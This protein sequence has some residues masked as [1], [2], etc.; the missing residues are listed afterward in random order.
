MKSLRNW[1]RPAVL[2]MKG[3]EPGE[4]PK[5]PTTIKLNTNENPY[6]PSAPV[7]GA[8]KNLE[9]LR[10]RRYPEPMADTLRHALSRLYHW[11]AEGILIGN[12]SDE[13]LSLVF[14]AS[15]GKGDVVQ[16]PDVT[17]SLY[18]S[19]AEFRE[20]KFKEVKLD[21]EFGVDFKKFSN[22]PRLTLW[23]Y[24]NPPIG[25]CFGMAEM[26]AFCRKAKGLVLI[27]EA[28][29]DFAEDNCISIA[30]S[31]SNV[32]V[33]RTMS[34][35]FSM[36]GIRLGYLFG[37]PQVV[38]QLM[39]VK[40]S[41]NISYMSQVAAIAA[42]SPL[43]LRNMKNNVKKIRLERNTLI[44]ALR[45]MGFSVPDS[46]ANF[47]LAMRS[48]KPSTESLYKNLKKNRILVRYFSH[49]RLKHSL[50]ISVG[51]PAENNRLLAELKKLL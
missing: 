11:P 37:H 36:A 16:C 1:F 29:V 2:K 26:K 47:I 27:D 50:R 6:P 33:L 3:Y 8:L 39:K 49:Q 44:E 18:R 38:T 40:D 31:C 19:I 4:Q 25:N 43:G 9:P 24:P 48:G 17:Y 20:A 10:L 45:N 15:V 21:A 22:T 35:S 5:Y 34:K 12:G 32:L 28:Y 46:Q 23:G 14:A 7:L 13:I 30:R 51:T 41:Y 42:I